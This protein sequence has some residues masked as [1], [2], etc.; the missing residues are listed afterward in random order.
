MCI[1]TKRNYPKAFPSGS[2]IQKHQGLVQKQTNFTMTA[3]TTATVN[4][5]AMPLAPMRCCTPPPQPSES[6]CPPSPKKQRLVISD[7][8]NFYKNE[9]AIIKTLLIPALEDEFATPIQS[10]HTPNL[11]PRITLRKRK[12]V[13]R[14]DANTMGRTKVDLAPVLMQETTPRPDS[15]KNSWSDR[16]SGVRGLPHSPVMNSD[17]AIGA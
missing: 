8:L 17:H 14:T 2:L 11:D 1:V 15:N 12:T 7:K 6:I 4:D 5:M 13:A 10:D 16:H 3:T 9:G